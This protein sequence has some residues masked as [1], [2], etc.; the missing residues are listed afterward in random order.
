[1]REDL[2]IKYAG[3]LVQV[4]VNLQPGQNLVI[5]CPLHAAAL[6]RA[7]AAAAYAAGARDV[8]VHY[9][10][11]A[12]ARLRCRLA[13][14][15]VLGEAKPWQS[16]RYLDY[17]GDCAGATLRIVSPD[18]AAFRG[19]DPERV[20]AQARARRLAM[21][22]VRAYTGKDRVQWCIAAAPS[23]EWAAAV[24]PSLG[25][26][27][28][29]EALWDA[30]FEVTRIDTP[31]PV[32]AW[33]AHAQRN[34]AY[35]DK[36]NALAPVRLYLKDDHGTD[37]VMDLARGARWDG[38]REMS[39]AGVPFIP[40]MPTEEVFTAPHSHGVHGTVVG[41]KPYVYN[42]D[43]I[44]GFTLTF[45]EGRVVDFSARTGQ[46]L[47]GRLLQE[48][49]GSDRL[50]EFALV[51]HSS[52]ISRKGLLFYNTLFDE[53]AACHMALG[54]SYV[55]CLPGGAAMTAAQLAERGM[56]QS[57]THADL[58]MGSASLSVEGEDESGR[59]F[60]LFRGGEWDISL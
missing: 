58:M 50:G 15:E 6:G 12:L 2:L 32:E 8:A 5:D 47:L 24:F 29:V 22:P 11:E 51:P 3:L 31:D 40:N 44:D 49:D 59:R 34:I 21:E 19:I 39:E 4:G 20:Q 14:R 7:C 36:L 57:T 35:R 9:E 17:I 28:A 45:R 41:S 53:N 48:A 46:E 43:I 52:P 13:P 23:P 55:S 25:Q 10:D 37:L 16:A 18:P 56:N 60:P 1:M 33:R 26:Q 30:I 38:A 27:E 42:G 54:Q